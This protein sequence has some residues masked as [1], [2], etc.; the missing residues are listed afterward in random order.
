MGEVC[1]RE[2][3]AIQCG[4]AI[5][6]P[7]M[8]NIDTWPN[9]YIDNKTYISY[10]LDFDNLEKKLT[11]LVNDSNKRRELVQNSQDIM[12]DLRNKVGKDYFIKKIFEIISV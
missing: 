5:M 2:F 10:D 4:T 12:N 9:I 11:N 6:F 3:E 7:D 8:S 1:Y